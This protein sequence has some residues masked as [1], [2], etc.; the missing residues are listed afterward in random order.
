[1]EKWHTLLLVLT[2]L[3]IKEGWY[4][5]D[6]S[7]P[8]FTSCFAKAAEELGGEL[9]E[10]VAGEVAQSREEKRESDRKLSGRARVGQTLKLIASFLGDE[11]MWRRV[12]CLWHAGKAVSTAHFKEQ[13]NFHNPRMTLQT[14]IGYSIG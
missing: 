6:L 13:K 1:M 2:Y 8:V 10:T 5:K 14:Y 3:G 4:K 12:R 11:I 9:A 7:L